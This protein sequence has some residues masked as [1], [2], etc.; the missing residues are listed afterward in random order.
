MEGV[1]VRFGDAFLNVRMAGEG[2]VDGVFGVQSAPSSL[3]STLGM[4]SRGGSPSAVS[5]RPPLR[6]G[7]SA[8]RAAA[9]AEPSSSGPCSSASGTEDD[10]DGGVKINVEDWIVKAVVFVDDVVSDGE[11][12][13]ARG[14]RG[15]LSSMPCACGTGRSSSRGV[16]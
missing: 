12:E 8:T 13:E 15:R 16:T 10:V 4:G 9:S 6:D 1:V 5:N 7:S 14:D 3:P 2:S 11:G